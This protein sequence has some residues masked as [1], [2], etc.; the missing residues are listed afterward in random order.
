M[1]RA[2]R[3]VDLSMKAGK[4]FDS[5]ELQ[6][7]F[8]SSPEYKVRRQSRNAQSYP[9][10]FQIGALARQ[11]RLGERMGGEPAGWKRHQK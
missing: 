9:G 8:L 4:E 11:I 1:Q 6:A 5:N 10:L 7:E 2:P 3:I